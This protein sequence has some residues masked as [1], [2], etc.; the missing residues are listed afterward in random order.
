MRETPVVPREVMVPLR[1][2]PELD[3]TVW[4]LIL[5]LRPMYWLS[6]K[7]PFLLLLNIC[8]WFSLASLHAL[9]NCKELC[10][11]SETA[12]LYYFGVT[13]PVITFIN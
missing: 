5:G 12:L 4:G 8:I 6:F 10:L 11:N 2:P 1:S 9:D 3:S 13:L 7:F